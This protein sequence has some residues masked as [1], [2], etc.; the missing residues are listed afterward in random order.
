MTHFSINIVSV[1]KLSS[2]W[3]ISMLFILKASLNSGK[4][5]RTF[6]VVSGMERSK[7]HETTK[8]YVIIHMYRFQTSFVCSITLILILC[9]FNQ[10]KLAFAQADHCDP[11]IFSHSE[12][13]LGYRLRGDRCEGRYLLL[14]VGRI[15]VV[16][17]LTEFFE[18]YEVNSQDKLLIEWKAPKEGEVR[19]SVQSLRPKLYYRMDTVRPSNSFSYHW[20]TDMLA[21]LDILKKDIGILGWMKYSINGVQRDVYLPLRIRQKEK[22]NSSHTY[23]MVLMPDQELREVFVSIAYVPPDGEIK[24]FLMD[25]EPLKFGYYPAGQ[26]IE[27]DVSDLPK[28]G[29]YYL[30]IGAIIQ[31]GGV[32]TKELWFY[33]AG[34]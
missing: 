23:Q 21:D 26:K 29:M 30:E 2:T 16:T 9:L 11:E 13:P 18:D 19:L 22:M 15:L 33:H 27:V 31:R 6:L 5:T 3:L 28:P 20:S 4:P 25:G 1:P 32:F 34:W 7:I 14:P 10:P 8:I 17:S 24:H 12:D